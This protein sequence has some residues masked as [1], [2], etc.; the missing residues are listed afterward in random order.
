MLY[1][2]I[3][4][5]HSSCYRIASEMI[6]RNYKFS[7]SFPNEL[8]KRFDS[9]VLQE[10]KYGDNR[11][12]LLLTKMKDYFKELPLEIKMNEIN[13]HL[14]II[15]YMNEY[16]TIMYSGDRRFY[17]RIPH[18][19]A[20]SESELQEFS[21]PSENAISKF[22]PHTRSFMSCGVLL[23]YVPDEF[24]KKENILFLI[25][26]KN[27]EIIKMIENPDIIEIEGFEIFIH[28]EN[29]YLY[30]NEL[31]LLSGN[32]NGIIS[33]PPSYP[34]LSK[35]GDSKYIIKWYNSI[36]YE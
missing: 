14:P 16:N 9:E 23:K 18:K 28:E 30:E 13:L 26:G 24:Y 35:I 6:K 27:Y 2:P 33:T 7:S 29:L 31:P 3:T 19:D 34:N 20:P 10:G 11:F 1:R 15:Q 22:N 32:G 8:L 25:D 36:P 17:Q 4:L 12:N 5:N 21:F